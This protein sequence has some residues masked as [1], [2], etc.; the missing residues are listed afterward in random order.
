MAVEITRRGALIGASALLIAKEAASHAA[1]GGVYQTADAM[2]S[3]GHAFKNATAFKVEFPQAQ[4][5]ALRLRLDQTQWPDAPAG[6]AWAFGTDV[7]F[8]KDLTAYWADGFDWRAQER[9]INRF[10]QYRARVDGQAIHFMFEKGSGPRPRPLLLMHGWPYSFVSFLDLIEPLAHPERFGGDV[11]DAFD[12]IVPSFPGFGFSD[13]P[14]VPVACRD[15]G[16]RLNTLMVDVLGYPR[17]LA[18]GGDWGG[19]TAEWLGLDHAGNV[20]GVHTNIISVRPAS[21]ARGSG[22]TDGVNTPAVVKFM[23][24]EK[25]E[26]P[27]KHAYALQQGSEPQ[28]LAFGMLDS[29]V[30]AAA[31]ILGKFYDWSDRRDRS[32]GQIFT[33]DQ[34]LTEVMIYQMTG[35]FATATWIYAGTAKAGDALP[36]G[37]RIEVPVAV[38]SF[39][40]PIAPI[41]PREFVEKSHHVVQWTDYP[42]GGHFPFYEVPNDYLADV[43][44]FNRLLQA[45]KL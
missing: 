4:L 37:R 18:A 34:L 31:W 3:T 22:G 29:P 16:H 39:P 13:K 24:A 21:G 14:A 33:R 40:D 11:A 19:H 26:Y 9:R 17:Y 35:T 5:D 44:R 15:M 41:P 27:S 43:R 10:A 32:F 23:Q 6:D 2:V 12:V 8:M 42:R 28:S 38:A 25:K 30:G 20:V 7:A 1:S 36:E 45:R